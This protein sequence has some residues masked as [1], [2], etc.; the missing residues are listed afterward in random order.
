[1][2]KLPVRR[3]P[4]W[5]NGS[6]WMGPTVAFLKYKYIVIIA[7]TIIVTIVIVKKTTPIYILYI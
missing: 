4:W 5:F 3:A 6:S 1:M 7:T 2:M